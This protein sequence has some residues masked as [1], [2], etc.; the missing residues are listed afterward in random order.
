VCA[1]AG[2]AETVPLL[3]EIASAS[4]PNRG[5]FYHPLWMS[6]LGDAHLRAGQRPEAQQLLERALAMARRRGERG[7]AAWILKSMGDLAAATPGA[8]S[9][10]VEGHYFEALG[11]AMTLGMR[12]LRVHCHRGLGELYRRMDKPLAAEER[13]RAGADLAAELGI[14]LAEPPS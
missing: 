3:E 2:R 5:L 6:W 13:L 10:Q 11:L 4:I 8:S 12:T 9:E 7:H 14:R 1:L